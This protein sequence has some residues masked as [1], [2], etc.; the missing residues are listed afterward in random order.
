MFF[1]HAAA[2]GCQKKITDK[3]K[4]RIANEGPIFLV[5]TLLP[6]PVLPV[7]STSS[8]QANGFFLG[9]IL[10]SLSALGGL[11]GDYDFEIFGFLLPVLSS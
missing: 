7:L 9:S 4:G 6:V 5:F 8:A 2:E 10:R 3:G 1:V 11:G